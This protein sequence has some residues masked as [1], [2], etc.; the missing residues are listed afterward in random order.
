[1]DQ[2]VA[3][4]RKKVDIQKIQSALL[5]SCPFISFAFISGPDESGFIMPP[6]NLD[7]AV[8]LDGSIGMCLA[9]ENILPVM[10]RIVPQVFC[11][12]TILNRVDPI[13]RHEVLQKSPLFVRET[14]EHQYSQFVKNAELDYRILRAQYRRRGVL[15]ES[16]Q[17]LSDPMPFIYKKTS[18]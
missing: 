16:S 2:K 11:E 12:L 8:Y 14:G 18:A 1:M 17:M 10:N 4:K 3:M 15:M 6:G 13:T 9:L 7:L 5:T